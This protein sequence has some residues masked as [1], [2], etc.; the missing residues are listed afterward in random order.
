MNRF[1]CCSGTKS[2]NEPTSGERYPPLSTD[3]MFVAMRPTSGAFRSICTGL[4]FAGGL[5]LAASTGVASAESPPFDVIGMTFVSSRGE[6]TDVVVHAREAR[7]RP[8]ADVAELRVVRAWVSTGDEA[9]GQIEIECDE[10]TLNLKSNSFWARGNVRGRT[11]DGREFSAPW[12]RYDHADG[13]LFTDA[14]V[15]LSEAGTRIRGGGF[16]YYVREQ[17]FRLLGGAEVIQE[18]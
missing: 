8:A 11:S 13:L 17:R 9:G 1:V 15:V 10:G 3:G 12:A 14:P 4:R 18:P 2:R 7:F 6:K 16:R 5:L